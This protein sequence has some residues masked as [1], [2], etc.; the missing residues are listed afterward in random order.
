MGSP[1]NGSMTGLRVAWYV[2]IAAVRASKSDVTFSSRGG[3][4]ADKG[5]VC[6]AIWES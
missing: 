2:L 6:G 3:C 1:F 4:S 5:W